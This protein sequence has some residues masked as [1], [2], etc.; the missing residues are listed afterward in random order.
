MLAWLGTQVAEPFFMYA[1]A[2]ETHMPYIPPAPYDTMF[3]VGSAPDETAPLPQKVEHAKALYDGAIRYNDALLGQLLDGLQRLGLADRTLVLITAD[4]GEAFFAHEG[5]Y[6]HQSSVYNDQIRVPLI[7]RLPGVIP[8]DRD[9]EVPV[10]LVDILPTVSELLRLE[11]WGQM[12]GESLLS[13]LKEDSSFPSR[14]L[15]SQET[16]G[17]VSGTTYA[18]V[19]DGCWKC[20]LDRTSGQVELY[21]LEADPD[22]Q[23]DLASDRADQAEAYRLHLTEWLQAEQQIAHRWRRGDI[24]VSPE[25]RERLRGLGYFD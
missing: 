13:L 25:E 16:T 1:H 4:H 19:I 6:G 15:Y 20:I 10:S 23:E 18:C 7:L 14:K 11:Y 17:F 24:L 2:V 3:A 5:L 12:E 22:E 9:V 8:S 21:D